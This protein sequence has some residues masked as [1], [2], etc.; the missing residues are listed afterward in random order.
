MVVYSCPAGTTDPES[1]DC[2]EA[3]TSGGA[4]DEEKVT[5]APKKDRVYVVQVDGFEVQDEGKFFSEE[6]LL[7]GVEKGTLAISGVSPVFQIVYGFDVGASALLKHPLFTSGAFFAT[8]ALTLK[9]EDGTLMGQ[10][11][12]EIRLKAP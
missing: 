9:V 6:S 7:F 11:P 5:F 4:T 12:A 10:I 8:G 2:E 1:K 3:G